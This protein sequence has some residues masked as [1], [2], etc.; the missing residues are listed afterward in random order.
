MR[1]VLLVL[2]ISLLLVTGC[3]PP[4]ATQGSAPEWTNE[5][6]SRINSERAAVGASPLQVCG[7]LVD[8][9]QHHSEDQ[10]ARSTMSHTG[11]NGSTMTQRG[12][13]AGYRGWTAMA[14]NVAAGQASVS[15]VMNAWMASPG[16][17]SN[18]R[19]TTYQ[20]VGMGQA[21]SASGTIYWT[22][23]FGRGGTC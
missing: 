13:A 21:R 17:A 14:E 15:S 7:A 16:H 19:S 23:V 2:P 22:Q 12:E 4:P 5:M 10:A 1:R 9:A 11:A 18:L 8:A 3:V 20:H 6:L